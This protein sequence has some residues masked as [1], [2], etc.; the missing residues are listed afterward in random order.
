MTNNKNLGKRIK[1]QNHTC[2]IH[3]NTA[4]SFKPVGS[5]IQF[6]TNTE[7]EQVIIKKNLQQCTNINSVCIDT[8]SSSIVGTL[9]HL[10]GSLFIINIR[11][12][13]NKK[14]LIAIIN[15]CL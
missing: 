12:A 9:Y 1:N 11:T 4:N 2:T 6:L 7:I 8:F 15:L 3:R 14:K 13:N 10:K 5:N